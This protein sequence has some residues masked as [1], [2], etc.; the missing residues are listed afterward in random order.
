[1]E[2]SLVCRDGSLRL[3]PDPWYSMEPRQGP[4]Q[5]ETPSLP[6]RL[7]AELADRALLMGRS[8]YGAPPRS[9]LDVVIAVRMQAWCRR[10]SDFRKVEASNSSAPYLGVL[11]TERVTKSMAANQL[12]PLRGNTYSGRLRA[13]RQ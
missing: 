7:S 9:V 13:W 10:C 6:E 3:Y 4:K 11:L 12:A 2:D 8:N 5:M 1:M